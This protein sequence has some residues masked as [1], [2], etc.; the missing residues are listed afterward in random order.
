MSKCHS[1]R[2]AFIRSTKT[3]K[4]LRRGYM[5]DF[6]GCYHSYFSQAETFLWCWETLSGYTSIDDTVMW[7]S[8]SHTSIWVPHNCFCTAGC[9][10][11]LFTQARGKPIRPNQERMW[12]T[13]SWKNISISGSKPRSGCILVSGPKNMARFLWSDVDYSWYCFTSWCKICQECGK[14]LFSVGYGAATV[15]QA[16][17]TI[18]GDWTQNC[19]WPSQIDREWEVCLFFCSKFC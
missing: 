14:Y 12:N 15:P 18:H 2:L 4:K 3:A 19:N 6:E 16:S 1:G 17:I 5:V 8:C 11:S 10:W 13:Y 9:W 7:R